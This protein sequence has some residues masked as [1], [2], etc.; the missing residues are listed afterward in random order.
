[1]RYSPKEDLDKLDRLDDVQ[2]GVVLRYCG[3]K[4]FRA[5]GAPVGMIR[6]DAKA[7]CLP[8]RSLMVYWAWRRKKDPLKWSIDRAI[9]EIDGRIPSL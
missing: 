6:S 1:M 5:A 8:F 9:A 7:L 3:G 2:R 4:G